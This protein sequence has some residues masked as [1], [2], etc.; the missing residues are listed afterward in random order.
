ME[1]WLHGLVSPK[2][3]GLLAGVALNTAIIYCFLIV[4]LRL[5]GRRTLA[6][7]SS[8]DLIVVILLG[9]AVETSMVR[10]NTMLR[11]G[12][13]AASVLL[14]LN[15]SLTRV[16]RRSRRLRHLIGG[17]PVLLVHDGRF[18]LDAIRRAGFTLADVR[19]AMR[20]R[21][22]VDV[23]EIRFAVLEVDGR[24]NVV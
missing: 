11:C 24:I 13:V 20:G 6:Q 14:F 5:L 16:M 19:A 1:A 3:L 7:L 15:W 10:A 21:E 4:L 18:M 8:M 2:G 12:F 23:E 9:S 17:G 22:V